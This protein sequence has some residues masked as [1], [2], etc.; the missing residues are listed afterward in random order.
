MELKKG[1]TH[2][3]LIGPHTS[4][5]LSEIILTAVDNKLV[6][7]GWK[8]IRHIDD[9]TCHVLSYEKAQEFLIDLRSCLREYDLSL[10]HKKSKNHP[11]SDSRK[12]VMGVYAKDI[13]VD[14][15]G[16]SHNLYGSAG[17][18]GYGNRS[19]ANTR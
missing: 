17:I 19:D 5:L 15:T 4:N 12:A 9:Y 6:A 10:N 11:S 8:Y 16:R 3:F 13:S 7:A 1:E 18:F 14:Q 2:G